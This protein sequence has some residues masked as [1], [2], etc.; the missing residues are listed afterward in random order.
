MKLIVEASWERC[1]TSS[2]KG[3]GGL[4]PEG[5]KLKSMA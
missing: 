5:G 2:A 3:G 4:E 1:I